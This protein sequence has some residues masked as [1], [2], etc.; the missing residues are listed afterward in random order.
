MNDSCS[1]LF[2]A[3]AVLMLTGAEAVRA[4]SGSIAESSLARASLARKEVL[5]ARSLNAH[6]E[7]PESRLSRLPA[8][9]T[10][11][12]AALFREVSDSLFHFSR[13]D[14][15]GLYRLTRAE[16]FK[17]SGL[18]ENPPVWA[19]MPKEFKKRL[20]RNP[21][22]EA[23]NVTV[24]PYPATVTVTIREAEPWF[25]AEYERHSWIVSREGKLVQ[26]LDTL[27]NSDIILET[28]EL[29]RLDGLASSTE[30]DSALSS[31]NARFVHA[32]RLM[33]FFRAAGELPFPV[34]RYTL[35]PG[36]GLKVQSALPEMPEIFLFAEN[37]SDAIQRLQRLSSVLADLE[38]RGEKPKRIDL[39]FQNQA[40][41]E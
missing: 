39:R 1:K 34:M 8:L 6:S 23:A 37:L 3:A 19:V 12:G 21:W 2:L 14:F 38:R 13:V 40:I 9:L 32:I 24:L 35:L 26:A 17:L 30:S 36:G 20:L 18:D 29:P 7:P 4:E 31:S 16:V 22:I 41:V 27:D 25:I 11:R 15:E 10:T 28:A 5:E 33:K